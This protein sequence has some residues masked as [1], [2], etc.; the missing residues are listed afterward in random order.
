MNR[1]LEK[2]TFKKRKAIQVRKKVNYLFSTD[3]T[4]ILYVENSNNST[5]ICIEPKELKRKDSTSNTS[6]FHTLA[7]DS[8]KRKQCKTGSIYKA[9]KSSIIFPSC[10]L[11]LLH[12]GCSNKIPQALRCRVLTPDLY[13]S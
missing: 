7:M 13:F 4:W 8:L 1:V 3:D 11:V 10:P 5:K 12:L 2:M 6:Y 9:L